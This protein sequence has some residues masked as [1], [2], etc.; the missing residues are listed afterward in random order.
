[1]SATLSP[2]TLLSGFFDAFG[3]GDAPALFALFADNPTVIAVREA[4]P[5]GAHPHGL[6]TGPD[7]V[8]RFVTALGATFDTQ[9]FSVDDVVGSATTAFASGSFTHLVRATNKPFSSIWA[10]RIEAA[11]GKIASFRF[12]ED[13]AAYV[14]AAA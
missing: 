8:E 14:S 4:A 11:D 7:A 9:A 13:S 2:A 1:M 5:E 12:Y 10:A 6:Y 3:R